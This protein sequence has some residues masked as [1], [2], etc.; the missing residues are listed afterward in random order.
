MRKLVYYV[1]TSLD[2][3]IAGP[4]HQVDFYPLSDEMAAWITD[5]YPE[6]VPFHLREPAGLV[7]AENLRFD[8]VVMGLGTYR[9]A[10]DAGIT[11]PYRHLREVVVSA[12]LR[13]PDPEVEVVAADVLERVRELKA[14]DGDHDIWLCGGGRLAGSLLDEIDEI[15]LKRYPVVAGSGIPVLDGPFRPTAFRPTDSIAFDNGALVTWFART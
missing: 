10:L 13:D 7:E 3:Y 11:R 12:S 4:E 8:T 5:R 15:V 9:P 1:G 14:E 2:G 6:T